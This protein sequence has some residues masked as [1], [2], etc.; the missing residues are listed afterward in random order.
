M[1]WNRNRKIS[2]KTAPQ[3]TLMYLTNIFNPVV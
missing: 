1:L 2:Q 3:S